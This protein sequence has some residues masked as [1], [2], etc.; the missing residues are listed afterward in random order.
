MVHTDKCC[1]GIRVIHFSKGRYLE[2]GFDGHEMCDD[3]M[4]L[5][6]EGPFLL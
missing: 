6:E 3:G 4:D 1:F 5:E 2:Y